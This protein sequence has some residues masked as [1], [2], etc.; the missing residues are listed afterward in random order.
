MEPSEP[1]ICVVNDSQASGLEV[2]NLYE[3]GY[4][5]SLSSQVS[6]IRCHDVHY[7]TLSYREGMFVD[8]KGP[9]EDGFRLNLS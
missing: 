2:S 4:P 6:S 1:T 3:F 9:N 8:D 7:H 5:G